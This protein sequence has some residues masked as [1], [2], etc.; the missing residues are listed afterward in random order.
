MSQ[1]TECF[2]VGMKRSGPDVHK[3]QRNSRGCLLNYVLAYHSSAQGTTDEYAQKL[4]ESSTL[5][6]GNL[7]FY[8]NEDQIYELFGMCGEVKRVIMGLD[9]VEQ[10][11]CG[12]CFVEYRSPVM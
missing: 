2:Q 5:Y 1:F 4:Q 6:V 9:R 8:T 10:T 3:Y 11:P 12:F 7:S